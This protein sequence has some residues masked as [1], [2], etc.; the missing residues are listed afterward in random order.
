M[1]VIDDYL[2]NISSPQKEEL[3]RLLSLVKQ[4]VPEAKEVITYGMPGFQ[5]RGKY[6]I[7]I[8]TFKDHMSIFPGSG[9]IADLQAE[10][11]GY[12]QSKGTIQFTP[13][14]PIPDSLLE[15][16]VLACRDGISQGESEN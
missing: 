14:N 12:K 7:S 5:F 2:A 9:P 1:S 4:T 10:L 13:E 8:G 15:R 16:I 11:K 6:L 3:Q